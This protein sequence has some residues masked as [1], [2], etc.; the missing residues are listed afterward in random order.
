M[1]NVI[2]KNKGEVFK[3]SFDVEGASSNDI[4]V[5]LCLEFNDNKNMFFY[6]QMDKDGGCTIQ[7]PRLNELEDKQGTLRVEA[8]IDDTYFKLHECPVE[9]RNSVQMKIKEGNS[10][11]FDNSGPS[12]AKIQFGRL[13]K[14]TE[15]ERPIQE[16]AEPEVEAEPIQEE[17]KPIDP[18]DAR[19]L[20]SV[21]EKSRKRASK[22]G[23][24]K[25]FDEWNKNNNG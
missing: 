13:E 9:L 10:S 23:K 12:G 17:K 6:G 1:S 7:I 25:S 14:E 5:R 21:L 11:F 16:Q 8:I 20:K 2:Y 22:G 24:F 19:R 3:C 15:L 4:E 18:E